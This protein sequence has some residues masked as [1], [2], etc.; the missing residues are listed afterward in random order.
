MT[1]KEILKLLD[2]NGI[3]FVVIGGTA[4][5]IYNSPRL[6]HDIDIA[7]Q[8]LE[9]DAV[10]EV[11]YAHSYYLICRVEDSA[12]SVI[13]THDEAIDW[14][15]RE[16][17]GAITFLAPKSEPQGTEI[18]HKDIDITTQVDFV[19]EPGIPFSVLK[20][21]AQKVDLDDFSFLIASAEDLLF[22]KENRK[23][24]TEADKDDIRFLRRLIE[25]P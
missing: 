8:T 24:K 13:S 19:F 16:K 5:R 2:N 4:L 14:V 12:C 15:E 22:M 18:P 1:H 11:M 25:S 6:T 17:A 10:I 7:I 3:S 20:K 23:D 9:I 21:N